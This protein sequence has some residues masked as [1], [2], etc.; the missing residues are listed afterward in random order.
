MCHCAQLKFWG[1]FFS[2]EEGGPG[3]GRL[4]ISDC[5][6]HGLQRS[7][8]E[9][10]GKE[11]EPLSETSVWILCQVSSMHGYVTHLGERLR[12]RGRRG[13]AWAPPSQLSWKDV[14]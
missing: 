13:L 5:V 4:T 3:V 10:T 12:D 7:Q 1:L 2:E 14:C 6:V 9:A 11:W 8:T